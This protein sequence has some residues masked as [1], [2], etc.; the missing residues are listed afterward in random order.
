MRMLYSLGSALVTREELVGAVQDEAIQ[1][2]HEALGNQRAT[3]R[4]AFAG[5][6]VTA[7]HAGMAPVAGGAIPGLAE[8]GI[9]KPLSIEIREIYTGRYP[10]G[11]SL[12]GSPTSGMLVT[13]AMKGVETFSGA[14]RA[15]NF[16]TRKVGRKTRLRDV[17]AT[18]AGTPVVYYS[19]ALTHINS[20]LTL[21]MAFDEFP[22]EAFDVIATAASTAAG[23]PAF[24]SAGPYLVVASTIVNLAGKIGEAGFDSSPD[25]TETVALALDR[26]G[27]PALTADYR[28]CMGDEG[29]REI[30][31]DYEVNAKGT[32]VRKSDGAA[33]EGD[34][35]Y[36]VLSIDGHQYDERKAFAPTAATAD[37]VKT[38]FGSKPLFSTSIE[39]AVEG[40]KLYSDWQFR[41]RALALDKQL[42][43]ETDTAKQD[44]LRALRDAAVKNIGKDELKP[45]FGS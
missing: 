7:K 29:L 18:T 13:T 36:I 26:P 22:K 28:L 30:G 33:Y 23:I 27:N 1:K 12:F 31:S 17:D 8:V 25:F 32:L 14:A 45:T 44:E 34:A 4:L 37:M 19:P 42:K 43:A 15:V 11:L 9:G 6:E 16:L 5:G 2:F 3:A 24:A 21:D 39:T 40:M 20:V 41:D 10:R 38:F 35:P